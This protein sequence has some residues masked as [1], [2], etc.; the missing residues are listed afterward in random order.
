MQNEDEPPCMISPI[1]LRLLPYAI[2]ILFGYIGFALPLPILPEMFLDPERSILPH[3]FSMEKRNL[4][5]GLFMSSYPLG[6]FI[7]APLLGKLSDFWGRKKVITYSLLT[8]TIGY[9]VTALGC[10]S[11]TIWVIFGGL[12]LC[13]FSEGNVS[14]A[15]SVIADITE[16]EKKT[17][18]FGWINMFVCLGF[19][20]GPLVGGKLADPEFVSFFTFATPFWGAAIMT[21]LGLVVVVIASKETLRPRKREKY[22]FFEPFL[23][24]IRSSELRIYYLAN[25][26]LALGFFSFF[27]FMPVYF[28]RVFDFTISELAYAMVYNSL[29]FAF[30]LL[31]F[32]NPL[33]KRFSPKTLTS[34]F[35][36]L[37]GLFITVMTLPAASNAVLWTI[38]PIGIALAISMTNGSVLISNSAREDFH[39][40]AMGSLQSVQVLA[41]II[42]GILGGIVAA[43]LP[44]LPLYIGSVMAALGGIVLMLYKKKAVISA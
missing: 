42:T 1:T 30:T 2:V 34:A 18:H 19:I 33:A 7:G 25:F 28:E 32:I 41:E 27:R 16:K 31:L 9:G 13:G 26:L 6:Q 15:Q 37:L 24:I 22:R 12:F 8:T 21:L 23:V 17:Y 44:P 35:S 39:G 36:I 43:A 29:W 4:L 5:L 10:T 38:P 3:D 11:K 20:I 14:I 40:S